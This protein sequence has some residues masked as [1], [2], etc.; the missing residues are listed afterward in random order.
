MK[1]T[2]NPR[3]EMLEGPQAFERFQSAVKVALTVPKSA[4][5]EPFGHSKRKKKKPVSDS[6]FRFDL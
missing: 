4:I 2:A 5:P 6:A 1:Q 3:P